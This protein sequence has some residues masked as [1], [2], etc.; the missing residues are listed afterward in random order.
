MDMATASA[1]CSDILRCRPYSTMAP[2][3]PALKTIKS[4]FKTPIFYNLF[5]STTTTR[6]WGPWKKT[7][8]LKEDYQN[9][10]LKIPKKSSTNLF[11]YIYFFFKYREREKIL[12]QNSTNRK[13]GYSLDESTQP[14]AVLLQLMLVRE[15]QVG[16]RD[17]EHDTGTKVVGGSVFADCRRHRALSWCFVR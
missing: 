8:S 13:G 3:V 15:R 5:I 2:N 16:M 17:A 9:D 12:W 7:S 11:T 1:L 6:R 14:S 10:S 4:I